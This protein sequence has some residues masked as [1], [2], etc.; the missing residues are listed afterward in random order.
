VSD[1]P[2]RWRTALR[3]LPI[4]EKGRWAV[5]GSAALALHGLMVEPSDLDVVADPV[6][7]ASLAEHLRAFVVSDEATWDRGDVRAVRRIFLLVAG[8]GVEIMVGVESVSNGVVL[9][10]TPN[11]D[12]LDHVDINEVPIPVLPLRTLVAI[13]EATGKYERALMARHELTRRTY[14]PTAPSLRGVAPGP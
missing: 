13:L 8:V 6:A 5:T 10:G 11:L 9:V 2:H 7:A 4:L 14:A 1:E 3:A 12:L